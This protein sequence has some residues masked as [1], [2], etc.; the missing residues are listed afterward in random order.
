M[1]ATVADE[2]KEWFLAAGTKKVGPMSLRRMQ[3]K[4]AQGKVPARAKAWREGMETW[5]PVSEIAELTATETVVVEPAPAP[6]PIARPARKSRLSS[7]LVRVA[8]AAFAQRY[9]IDKAE[10][11]RAFEIGFEPRRLQL[12]LGVF[13]A[14]LGIL[15]GIAGAF[16]LNPTAGFAAFLLGGPAWFAVLGIGMGALSYQT[17]RRIEEA[18]VPSPLE[19]LAFARDHALALVGAPFLLGL[20]ALVPPVL[21]ILK[22]LISH[23]PSIG[24]PL[25]GASF[26]V[27]LALSSMGV[28]LG[29]A[30]MLGGAFCPVIVAFEETSPVATIRSLL[31]VV[32]TSIVRIFFWQ[33]RPN[34]AIS[35]MGVV[36]FGLALVV[37]LVPAAL[38]YPIIGAFTLGKRFTMPQVELSFGLVMVGVWT[39]V[40][41]SLV[42]AALA[43]TKNA[44]TGLVYLGCRPG[45]DEL[46]TRDDYVA[47]KQEAAHEQN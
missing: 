46:M 10:A 47:R 2:K 18:P 6:A 23:I 37:A 39:A 30:C 4:L 28:F 43:S 11:W 9:R 14:L 36:L 22:S 16:Y 29:I 3:E 5:L 41:M 21:M 15:A 27:D 7:R 12:L 20:L 8:G 26:G 42:V 13:G 32:K 31:A 19:A 45:N 35:F 24:A 17:R 44:L 1:S 34:L 38:N 33:A 40:L 25:A